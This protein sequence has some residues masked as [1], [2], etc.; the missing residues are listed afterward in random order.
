MYLIDFLLYCE[1][2]DNRDNILIFLFNLMQNL[3]KLS[4]S[5]ALLFL[6]IIFKQPN[7]LSH[8]EEWLDAEMKKYTMIY[9]RSLN[10][11]QFS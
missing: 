4:I 8:F 7:F 3:S 10:F 1:H 2:F 11:L 5:K 6:Y 9:L